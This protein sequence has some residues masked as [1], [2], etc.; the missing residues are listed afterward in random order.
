MISILILA[1]ARIYISLS[2]T[3]LM[4]AARIISVLR[5]PQ[6]RF[7]STSRSP[8]PQQSSGPMTNDPHVYVRNKRLKMTVVHARVADNQNQKHHGLPDIEDF[9]FHKPTGSDKTNIPKHTCDMLSDTTMAHPPTS[10]DGSPANWEK[11]LEEIRNMRSSNDAPVDSMGCE[12]AGS[13]LPP[14]ERR[15]AVLIS[16]LLSSQTKDNITHGAIQRLLQ[17][18]LLSAD[19]I[20]EADEATIKSIIYP[21]GFYTRKASNMKKVAEICLNDYGGD[22]PDTLDKLLLLPGIGPKMAHLG[23][24]LILMSTVS[25]TALVGFLGLVQSRKLDRLKRQ[26]NRCSYGFPKKNG[27]L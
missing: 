7:S 19:A 3:R 6:T 9:A 26:E 11:V 8:P 16:S 12:K 22:I 21:V 23:F 10:I 1:D 18:G 2:L 4:S 14:K 24:V 15:F 27:L 5:M 17:N 25:A 13:M 20:H